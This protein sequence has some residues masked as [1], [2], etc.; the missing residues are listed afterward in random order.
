MLYKCLLKRSDRSRKFLDKRFG[1]LLDNVYGVEQ[2][3]YDK[4]I[5][6]VRFPMLRSLVLAITVT[7]LN[8]YSFAVLII[9]YNTIFHL[10]YMLGGKRFEEGTH[11]VRFDLIVEL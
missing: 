5:D 3:K 7:R 8:N 11:G 6:T 1:S 10:G 4:A 2:K 9:M